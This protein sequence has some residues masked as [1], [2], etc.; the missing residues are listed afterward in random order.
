MAFFQI[1][2]ENA[3]FLHMENTLSICKKS[4]VL[5]TLFFLGGGGGGGGTTFLCILSSYFI[6]TF[7]TF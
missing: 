5:G 4:A 2:T 7:R 1:G 6:K 3:D